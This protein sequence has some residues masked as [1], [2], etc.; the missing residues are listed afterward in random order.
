MT[1]IAWLKVTARCQ[2]KQLS[3]VQKHHNSNPPDNSFKA[4]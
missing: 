3:A 2:H 1:R 4:I